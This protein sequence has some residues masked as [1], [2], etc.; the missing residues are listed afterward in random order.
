MEGGDELTGKFGFKADEHL[1]LQFSATEVYEVDSSMRNFFIQV[2][3][4]STFLNP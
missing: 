1:F 2:S 3:G 4:N